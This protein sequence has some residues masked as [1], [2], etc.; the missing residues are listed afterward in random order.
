MVLD[1]SNA[2]DDFRREG[3]YREWPQGNPAV[4][5]LDLKQPKVDDPQVLEQIKGDPHLQ[6]IPVVIL[7]ASREEPDL[8]RCYRL[9]V[10]VYLVK[11]V[12][13]KGFIEAIQKLGVFWALITSPR[14]TA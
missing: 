12:S 5:P 3:D 1:G 2:L 10:N 13:F 6:S 11:P 14:R 7:T 4:V 9:G 8:L